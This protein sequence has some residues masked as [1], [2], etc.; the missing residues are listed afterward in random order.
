MIKLTTYV[1]TT[2]TCVCKDG[3]LY[4][5]RVVD[6]N[7]SGI[8]SLLWNHI[9]RSLSEQLI[10]FFSF[11]M[12]Q[13]HWSNF[14]R[15]NK[16]RH[17]VVCDFSTMDSEMASSLQSTMWLRW[18]LRLMVLSERSCLSL[19]CWERELNKWGGSF[20]ETKLRLQMFVLSSAC[21]SSFERPWV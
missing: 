9:F 1:F 16:V 10:N 8:K 21:F 11:Y 2:I 6:W 17:K 14:K 5:L 4:L 13:F 20:L 18:A 3:L 7:Q 19:G 12:I 15:I